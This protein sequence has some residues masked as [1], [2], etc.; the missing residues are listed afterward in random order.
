M[1]RRHFGLMVG[2]VGLIFVFATAGLVPT[3]GPIAA[4]CAQD[5]EAFE[6]DAEYSE[7]EAEE[8]Q[9]AEVDVADSEEVQ[10]T[11]WDADADDSTVEDAAP[12]ELPAQGPT[13]AP[14]GPASLSPVTDHDFG[15]M[16]MA[17]TGPVLVLF[18]TNA[19]AAC[20]EMVPALEAAA[21]RYVDRV[22]ILAMDVEENTDIPVK[23]NIRS[24]PTLLLFKGGEVV[25][26]NQGAVSRD[27]LEQFLAEQL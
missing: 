18:R 25:A 14:S 3:S 17:A 13:T 12:A 27:Q 9:E 24:L 26:T 4:A 10:A 8:G 23:F 19:C 15:S 21:G 11:D 6:E 7:A 1:T 16:V 22:S 20:V 2:M 5:D